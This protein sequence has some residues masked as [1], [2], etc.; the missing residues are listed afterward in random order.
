MLFKY[1][2]HSLEQMQLRNISKRVVDFVM[3]HP[4]VIIYEENNHQI[5][6]KVIEQHLYRVFV[7]ADKNPS[8]I[9]TVYKTSKIAKY[10][11]L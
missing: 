9:K 5:F 6:Q 4:D 11:T 3:E 2:K 7:T 8:L 10:D 1:S